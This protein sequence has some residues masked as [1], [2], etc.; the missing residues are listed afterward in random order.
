MSTRSIMLIAVAVL[1]TGYVLY[2]RFVSRL[3]G[4]EPERRTPAHERYDGVDYVPARHWLV[5]FGHHFSSICAAGPIVGPA[6]AVAYWGY[7]VSLIW[8]LAGGVVM[9]AVA[10]F[11][12]LIVAVRHGGVSISEVAGLVIT[13]RARM[14]FS[15]FILV[16]L[17]L[18]LAV[19]TH[20]AAGTFV[21]KPEI[22]LPS[23]GILPV[24]LVAGWLLYR[25][26]TGRS[27]LAIVTIAGLA[28]LV[29][30]MVAGQQLPVSIPD[31]ASDADV[32]TGHAVWM[33]LLLAYCFIASVLPV[34]Y[35]LQPRD[36]LSSYVLFATI[37][38]GLLGALW[39]NPVMNA[40]V[41]S[42]FLPDDWPAAG[43]LWPMMFV[44]IACGAISGFHSVV[45][46]G[47][48]CKQLDS[49]KHAC[50]IGYGAML[51]ESF[52]AVLVVVSVGGGLTAARHAE[53]LRA[54]GGAI[55]AFGE[56]Y[57]TLTGVFFGEYGTAFAVMALNF[58]ILTTLDTA[59]RLGRYLVAEL[60]GWH[61]R[62]LP[63]AV[64]VLAAAALALPGGWRTLWPA[65]GASNQLVA[66]LALLVVASWLLQRG[67]PSLPILI[68]SLLMLVTTLGALAWQVYGSIVAPEPNWIIAGIDVLLVLLALFVLAEAWDALRRRQA[69]LRPLSD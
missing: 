63:T 61:S 22:V 57:G 39:T 53:L 30:L 3:L 64:V 20:L 25:G 40:R 28:T 54:P 4:I 68:P 48:T 16:A 62:Y 6:L 26:T 18:V 55:N 15:V 66:A 9:G 7:G 45:S 24:A 58:F 56:G 2:G 5:L 67:R 12:S 13:P 47:T 38:L 17:V 36:Y 65:F 1:V 14:T 23:F 46:S 49:E 21:E 37:G 10:D 50:R 35:L 27:R 69:R 34:Q 44:T 60:F 41:S 19:F 11:S 59:T 43:P 8:I 32:L 42:G 51:V 52:V 33:V 31:F 29:L